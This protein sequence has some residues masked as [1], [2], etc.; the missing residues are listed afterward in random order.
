[1]MP[2]RSQVMSFLNFF[3]IFHAISTKKM[4]GTYTKNA[5]NQ[6]EAAKQHFLGSRK[7]EL[8]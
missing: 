1:M 6:V 5:G 2:K 4:Q 7:E 3:S 8:R